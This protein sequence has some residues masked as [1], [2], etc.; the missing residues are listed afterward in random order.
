MDE[1]YV[2][3]CPHCLGLPGSCHVC[4]SARRISYTLAENVVGWTWA[5]PGCKCRACK[6]AGPRP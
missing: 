6:R 1:F 5:Y 4:H 2:V 3:S